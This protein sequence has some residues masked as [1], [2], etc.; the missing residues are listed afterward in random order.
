MGPRTVDISVGGM[1]CASCVNRV[2]RKLNRIDGVQATV[3]LLTE[4]A[5]VEAAPE[6][7]DSSLVQAVE[8]AGYSARIITDGTAADGEEPADLRPRLLVS[9]VLTVPLLA[10]TMVPA[11][12]FDGVGVVA[13]LLSLPV[14]IWGAWPFHRAAAINARH[15]GATM[16]SLVSLGVIAASAWSV[17]ALLTGNDMLYFE[18][19]ATVTTFLLAGRTL[20]ARARRQS[21]AALRALLDLGAKDV[22]VVADESGRDEHRV[23]VENLR[24]G[25]LFVVRPGERIATDGTVVAGRSEVDES[26]LT[27]EPV[28]VAVGLGDEVTGSCVNGSGRLVV[29]ATRVGGATRLAQITRL[30]QSAQSGKARVQRLADRVSAVFVPFVLAMSA[31]TLT[32]WLLTTG[33]AERAFTAAVAV[34]IIACPCA[35]G[36]ATPTALLAG[37]GRGAQLGILISG[38]EVLEHAQGIDTVVL[39]KTGTLTTGRLAVTAVHVKQGDEKALLRAAAAVEAAGSHPLGRAIVEAAPADQPAV[40]DFRSVAGLGVEGTVEGAVVRVGRPTWGGADLA[41]EDG[42]TVVAVWID[43]TPAGSISLADTVKPEA[44]R[45]VQAL[46]ALGLTPHLLTG[47]NS[48][49]AQAV[50]RAVGIDHVTAGVM[51]EGKLDEILRLQKE[52]HK[53]AMVGDGVNDAAALAAADLGLAVGAGTDAAIQA[54]DITLIRDDLTTVA[55]AIMLSRRTLRVIRQNL[56][57]AFA[58]NVAALPLAAAGVLNPMIAGLAMALSSVFV[59]LSSLRLTRARFGP[60]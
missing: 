10:I 53:V 31:L 33:D 36:L 32:A 21:G 37:T 18:I 44:A 5:Q 51:P 35:L 20:E 12:R 38:P 14:V 26:M 42:R 46:K 1:T 45:T 4:R 27:G 57:W 60:A 29:R 15:G 52:G 2:E 17:V 43:G 6:V 40:S 24:V 54:A 58:Y 7:P 30:V 48:S 47:D 9:A 39:D 25:S 50:A 55:Q 13:L 22:A 34:L 16:D 11:F 59:V 23:P 19:A 41:V 3:N 8:S 56:F 49:S 28:P